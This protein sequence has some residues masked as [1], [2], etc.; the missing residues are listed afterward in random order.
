MI[1]TM[2]PPG[3]EHLHARAIDDDGCAVIETMTPPGVEH[4]EIPGCS[5]ANF[6]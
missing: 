6:R 4:I 3:V 1:E 5:A 2:T